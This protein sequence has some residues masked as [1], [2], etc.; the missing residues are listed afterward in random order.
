[1]FFVLVLSPPWR[2][3]LVLVLDFDSNRRELPPCRRLSGRW[4]QDDKGALS[5]QWSVGSGRFVS[6]EAAKPRSR[7][8]KRKRVSVSGSFRVRV[9]FH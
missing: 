8:G 6:R 2:T 9:P 3:V 7:E 4:G 5:D 1:V